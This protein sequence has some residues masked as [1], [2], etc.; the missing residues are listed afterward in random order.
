MA[1][2]ECHAGSGQLVDSSERRV[3]HSATPPGNGHPPRRRI[4]FV[5]LALLALAVG[6]TTML[7]G[8][9]SAFGLGFA[10]GVHGSGI[11]AVQSRTLPSFT[12]VDLAGSGTVRVRVGSRQSVMVQADAT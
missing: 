12:S 8:G 6:T 11:D 7:V 10:T 1:R 5:P 2:A 4:P 3:M 9:S